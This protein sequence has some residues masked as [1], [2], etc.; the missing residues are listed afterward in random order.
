M[1]A[2]SAPP[3]QEHQRPSL[4]LKQA[5]REFETSMDFQTATDSREEK[6]LLRS[7]DDAQRQAAL[8]A[9]LIDAGDWDGETLW[10]QW[11]EDSQ[12]EFYWGSSKP[13]IIR[14]LEVL[15]AGAVNIRDLPVQKR[16]R[17]VAVRAPP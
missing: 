6:R 8:R 17:P 12:V 15:Q 5:G 13:F 1:E 3:Q 14:E 9:Q 2:E 11:I 16:S 7:Q 10:L 4:R